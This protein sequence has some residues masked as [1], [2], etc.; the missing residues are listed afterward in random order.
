[1]DEK[2]K[3]LLDLMKADDLGQIPEPAGLPDILP[4]PISAKVIEEIRDANVIRRLVPTIDVPVSTRNLTVPVVLYG[5][6][7]NVRTIGY[8]EDVTGGDETTFATKSI[9]IIP[10]LLV[11]YV[12]LIQDDLESAGVDLAKYIRQALTMKIADAEEAAMIAGE[13]DGASGPY[14]NI[15]DGIYTVAAGANCAAAPVTYGVDDDLVE[16]ISD[17]KKA[18]GAY[19]RNSNDL[20]LLCSYTFAN[21]LRKNEKLIS[22]TFVPGADVVSTGTLPPVMGVKV[23]EVA[24]LDA[25]DPGGGAGEVAILMR[26]DAFLLGQRKMIW[27]KEKE[28]EET[29]KHR[30]IMAEEIDFKA[31]FLNGSD[32]YEGIVMIGKTS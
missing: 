27:V 10:R 26:K 14:S 31:Q 25:Q 6:T 17:A 21:R 19:G 3:K 5:A 13:Y 23:I 29:F 22:V 18:L 1:M 28:L 11:T 16:K 30:I 4:K 20:I 2:L 15:F 12:D 9:V 8:G 24:G 32:K 7:N